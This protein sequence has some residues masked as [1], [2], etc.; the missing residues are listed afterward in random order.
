VSESRK[1]SLAEVLV[2][3]HLKLLRSVITVIRQGLSLMF[4]NN[5]LLKL[6]LWLGYDANIIRL[7]NKMSDVGDLPVRTFGNCLLKTAVI[8][9]PLKL[10]VLFTFLT[11]FSK[12][13]KC[14]FMFFELLHTFSR[15][16][17]AM[18]AI[19]PLSSPHQQGQKYIFERKRK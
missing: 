3:N 6:K 11:F 1:T 18:G 2:L 13:K 17:E 10:Y 4:P 8:K 16:L 7:H 19:A 5:W 15:M 9:W 14:L 12:S